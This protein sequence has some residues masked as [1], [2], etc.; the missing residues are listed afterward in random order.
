ML[1]QQHV[2]GLSTA[3]PPRLTS[4]ASLRGARAVA[5]SKAFVSRRGRANA[6][7]VKAEDTNWGRELSSAVVR[8][9]AGVLMVHNGLDKLVDPEGFAKFVV[10]PYLGFLP[11]DEPLSFVTWTYLAAA[12]ELAGAAGLTLGFLTR[13]S[14]MSLFS[15]MGLA[16]YFHIAQSGLEGFPLG[17]VEKHQYAYEPAALYCLIYFYFVVNGGGALSLDNALKKDD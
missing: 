8:V 11:H 17:V 14:A 13:L 9:G 7:V 5:P 1:T 6:V 12:A 10:E 16:V 4:R 3:L 2:C 15:T